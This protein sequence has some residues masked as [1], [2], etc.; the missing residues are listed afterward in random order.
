MLGLLCLN[1]G[2]LFLRSLTG[3]SLLPGNLVPPVSFVIQARLLLPSVCRLLGVICS[4]L[5]L[6]REMTYFGVINAC[7]CGVNYRSL[8]VCGG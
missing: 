8:A 1:Q 5:L 4:P 3:F 2:S 7:R 6:L